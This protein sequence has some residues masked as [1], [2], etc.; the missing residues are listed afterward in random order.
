M[1]YE[2]LIQISDERNANKEYIMKENGD[3]TFTAQF[4]RVGASY[5]TKNYNMRLWDS[6]KREKLNKG[7]KS[8]TEFVSEVRSTQAKFSGEPTIDRLL[9]R[10][11]EASQSAFS[12]TYRVAASTITAAQVAEVQKLINQA[13]FAIKTEQD[14]EKTRKLF[15]EIWHVLPRTMQNVKLNL[16]KS[17][18]EAL[19]KL[20]DEQDAIDNANVQSAFVA[21]TNESSLLDNL[22]IVLSPKLSDSEIPS[23]VARLVDSHTRYIN[24]I[25]RLT[26]PSLDEAF[27]AFVSKAKNPT[28]ELR[29]HGTKWRNGMAILQTG[30]K[31]L[32]SKS[33][34]YSGSML[35]DAIYT[36]K[37]FNKSYNYS[38]G[39][40]Y[41]LNVHT[42]NPLM[43][44]ENHQ[45]KHY[46]IDELE[47][48]GYDS[49]NADPGVYTG[50]VTLQRHEQTIYRAE[51]QT[52]AY[53]LD[54]K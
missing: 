50:R 33:A 49:V 28:T 22:G 29:F 21:D 47:K 11:L 13:N 7:Y 24:G 38:D 19:L 45:V 44:K 37:D 16:P 4:G 32:G 27:T 41:I 25:Y 5:Q 31:I 10:L 43:I 39:L 52:F 2:K 20:A 36:S 34:T 14:I 3:G 26:K 1:R 46:T 12:S 30:L 48:L 15:I 54:L 53:L 42:G 23:E 35:G 40:M 6:K 18:E 8:V 17:L 51:Q 9:E